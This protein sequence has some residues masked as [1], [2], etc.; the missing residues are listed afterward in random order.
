MVKYA[1]S[2]PDITDESRWETLKAHLSAVADLAA[3]FA[4]AFGAEAW[5][6]A[7]GLLH[8]IGKASPAF[9]AYLRGLGPSPDHSTAGA[10]V[11]GEVYGRFGRVLAFAIAG[12]H[13]GL[14]DWAGDGGRLAPLSERLRR[15]V[16]SYADW[17]DHTGPL[18]DAAALSARLSEASGFRPSRYRGFAQAFFVRMVFSC[19]V[20][21]DSLATEAFVAA[22]RGEPVPARGFTLRPEHRARL[23]A[24][25]APLRARGGALDGL[26]T[27]ILDYALAKA[28]LPPGL[29]T[30]TVPTGGGKTLT[31]LSFALEHAARHDLRRVVTVIPFTSII[32]QTAAV[33]R[34]ALGGEDD[35]LEHH[36]AFDWDEA[37]RNRDDEGTDGLKKLRR[38]TEN[39][40]APVVVTTS[41]QF[42]ESLF[43][44]RRGRCR[45]LHNLARSVIVIDEVQALPVELLRPCMAALDELVRNYGA[46]I[47]LCTAT[48]PALRRVDRALPRRPDGQEEGFDIAED[49]ELAPD[50]PRLYE[51]LRRTR[52]E[53]LPAPVGDETI[54]ARFA[55]RPQMLCIV[56][57]R[58][59][60]RD[61]FEAVRTLP[62][63]R[64][65]TTLMCPSH[66]RQVLAAARADLVAK[67]PVRLV[68]TSLIEAGVDI[69]FP[70]VWRAAAGLDAIIQAAGRCNRER[71]DPGLAP[72]V[73]FD[74]A[75][76][77]VPRYAER[78]RAA[79]RPALDMEDPLSLQAIA[80]YFRHLYFNGG[81]GALD[82][83]MA[84][85][86]PIMTAIAEGAP[87]GTPF[88][89]IADAFRMI[90]DT[91][92]P[93]IVPW[94]IRAEAA[95]A[96]LAMADR[97]P[98]EVL[99]ILQQYTVPIPKDARAR[100]LGSG[101]VQPVGPNAEGNPFFRL[102][103][104]SLYD[105][106]T[107]LRFEDPMA[108]SVESN[109]IS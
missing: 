106:E 62:G 32:E 31:S 83:R 55:E 40:D 75:D 107:G 95:L 46:T 54:A 74:A 85:G 42:F 21:A 88:A 45:K 76:R 81:H 58:A 59:H 26:R 52:V 19:L 60:A 10:A 87:L 37:A 1:H 94:D 15:P 92:A 67:R 29:F 41:V 104:L 23:A 56:N 109:I 48:Q 14:A 24:F 34:R 68:A 35:V 57:S 22:A 100:L 71:E 93:V 77:P 16:P 96:R 78:F 6:Q 90:E 82:E 103:D 51:R 13:A 108:R 91:M 84:A 44:A 65:L 4:S 3:A 102:A 33:F 53:R 2:L 63:A 27:E 49:R 30:L 97:P 64:H 12:H 50:P 39:W 8:D 73:V 25:M 36:A 5:G 28:A 17:R 105:G 79:A 98:R 11:A 20:D 99:R 7:A 18:P 69:S 72:V 66:R 70:E 61:L 9:Q 38:A 43:A 101:A 86:R 47:V 89:S 80:T